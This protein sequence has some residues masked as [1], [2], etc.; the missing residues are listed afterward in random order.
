MKLCFRILLLGFFRIFFLQRRQ[1][2][3]TL[4]AEIPQKFLACAKQNRLAGG[5][6]PPDLTNQP[7][8]QKP[9]HRMVGID[10][11]DF[12]HL[13]TR[14]RLLIGDNRQRFQKGL[15]QSLPLWAF[16]HIADI[17]KA[18]CRRTHLIRVRNLH[19][20]Q[21]PFFL[22]VFIRKGKHDCPRRCLIQLNRLRDGCQGHRVTGNKQQGLHNRFQLR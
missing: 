18:F 13:R 3:N 14:H 19:N 11:T 17:F 12:L 21:S 6:C 20:P 10:P 8:F 1:L 9:R 7:L 15:R 22:L 5:I 4:K 16:I 2:P